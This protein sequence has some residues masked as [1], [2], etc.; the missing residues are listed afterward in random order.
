M[1]RNI[2]LD[3]I[4]IILSVFVLAVH[5]G[6]LFDQNKMVYQILI[7]GLFIIAVPFFLC[8]NGFFL[9]MV[10][11]NNR[12]KVWLKRV[13]ILYIIWMLVYS[14]FWLNL[15]HF[16]FIKVIPIILFGFNHLW[17]LAALL[18]G[19]LLLYFF[20]NL[21]NKTLIISAIILY[22]LGVSIQYLGLFHVFSN[23]A[24]L[25]KIM[26][27]PPSHRNF[28]FYGLPFLSIGLVIKRTNFH[29]KIKKRHLYILLAM[30]FLLLVLDCLVNYYFL[31]HKTLVTMKLA[32]LLLGPVLFISAFRFKITSNINSKILSAY[33]IA[34]Y[35]AHP[36]IIFLII[37]Y[38]KLSPT[39]LTIATSILT[40]IASYF[41]IQLNSKL[42]YIL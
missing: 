21:S 8:T 1:E 26:N 31:T 6:F 33:S 15:T 19:G 24:F 34:I 41:L 18:V 11:K 40:V 7:N 4:K 39:V 20:Q 14:Y 5:C 28:L 35:L 2:L 29:L 25:D 17:Y 22:T 12:I 9:L 16:N 30:S 38:F 10:F 32:Y 37:N 36:L 42:K 13:A 23:Y 3:T 27:Y